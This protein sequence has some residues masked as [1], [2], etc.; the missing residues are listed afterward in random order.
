[1]LAGDEALTSSPVDPDDAYLWKETIIL[2]KPH[3]VPHPRVATGN[4]HQILPGIAHSESLGFNGQT[5]E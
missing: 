1:M 4:P 5:P 3:Y 2:Q